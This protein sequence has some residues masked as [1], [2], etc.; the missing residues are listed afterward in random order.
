MQNSLF[1]LVKPA[2]DSFISVAAKLADLI[3]PRGGSNNVAIDLIV[4]QVKT[5][6]TN[7]GK[8][9]NKNVEKYFLL[10]GYDP[11]HARAE[12]EPTIGALSTRSRPDSLHIV[13]QTPQLLGLH[14]ILRNQLTRRTEFIY[15][16][17]RIAQ[18]LI[19]KVKEWRISRLQTFI[20]F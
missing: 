4:R 19:E 14:T 15:V 13:E 8:R 7:R 6:L 9:L 12:L 3:V 18:I 20:M 5:Q 10:V 2:Y 17:D 16:T 1:F 11:M